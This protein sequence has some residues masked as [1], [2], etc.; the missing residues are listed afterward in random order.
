[1]IG[2]TRRARTA[3]H[4]TLLGFV[5][6]IG[7]ISAAAA[8]AQDTAE[9]KLQVRQLVRQLDDPELEVRDRAEQSLIKIGPASL[10]LLPPPDQQ[11]SEEVRHRLARVRQTIE[12]SAALQSL[13]GTQVTLVGAD[14]QLADVLAAIEEQT[15]NR[16]ELNMPEEGGAT[17][18]LKIAFEAT[19]FWTALDT[20]LDQAG[21]TVYPFNQ[22]DFLEIQ[23]A[24]SDIRS[25]VGSASYAGPFRIEP[26][27]IESRRD[28]R[29]GS[30]TLN[31]TL[32]IA[33]EPRLAP[34]ALKLP[35]DLLKATDEDGQPIELTESV[36]MIPIDVHGSASAAQ[37]SV[38]LK[39]PSRDLTKIARLRGTLR[40]LVPGRIETFRF[41][42]LDK[43]RGTEM[44]KGDVTVFLDGVRPNNDLWDVRVRV[45]FKD[46]AGALESHRGWIYQNERYLL[47]GADERVEELA[48]ELTAQSASAIGF[49]YAF[50]LPGG[51]KGVSF[52][53]KT[54]VMFVEMP[55]EFELKDIALP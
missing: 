30:H 12:R 52:V 47:T 26:T 43:A 39:A 48:M 16:I 42:D 7:A 5:A 40:A 41:D 14:L 9:L 33:W 31:L 46:A 49:T 21:A 11:P 38:P 4:R 35:F 2:R 20:V 45:E 3:S 23:P 22:A 1:M 29:T 44:S 28:L 50:D 27:S 51:P 36:T 25:R 32:E 37:V 8:I 53:Y 10:D 24:G 34:I 13:E 54:P 15:G 55:I 19:P 6:V 18:G 17:A